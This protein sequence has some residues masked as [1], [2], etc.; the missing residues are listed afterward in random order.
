MRDASIA[1]SLR[2]GYPPGVSRT[3]AAIS[4]LPLW[5][6]RVKQ[7]DCTGQPRLIIRH[8]NPLQRQSTTAA[9]ILETLSR[10]ETRLTSRE[11]VDRLFDTTTDV[12]IPLPTHI[13]LGTVRTRTSR[14][15]PARPRRT[16]HTTCRDLDCEFTRRP[17]RSVDYI[18]WTVQH[19]CQTA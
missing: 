15:R 7:R 19:H 17:P 10:Q 6:A 9:H 16:G 5:L 13:H 14:N 3:L 18:R 2:I 4:A 1:L 12:Y 8:L 11:H